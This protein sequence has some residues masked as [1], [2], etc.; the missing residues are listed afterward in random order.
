MEAVCLCSSV[1]LLSNQYDES[2]ARNLIPALNR[3]LEDLRRLLAQ[4]KSL[5][6]DVQFHVTPRNQ[7]TSKALAVDSLDLTP[8]NQVR[9]QFR[10]NIDGFWA[11]S[12]NRR[13]ILS[14]LR[15]PA[16]PSSYYNLFYDYAD[17]LPATDQLLLLLYAYGGSDVPEALLKGVRSPQ[18][19]WNS[20]GEIETVTSDKF[21]LPTELTNLLSDDIECSRATESPYINKHGLED[22]TNVWSLCSELAMFFSR[23]LT[24]KTMD[25]LGNVALKLLCF[26]VPPCYEGNTEWSPTLKAAVWAVMDKATTTFKVPTPLKAE[27]IDALL[28]FSERDHIPM[29]RAAVDRA[30]SF[31]RKPMPYYFH[32][33]VVLSRSNLLRLDGEFAKSEAHIRDFIWRGPQPSTRKDHALLGRL[34][35]SQIENKI[36]CYDNDVSSFIYNWQAEQPLSTLDIEV[37]FR[38]QSTAAR[39]FQSI[40][41]FGAARA[42]I[43]HLMSLD[44]TKPIRQNTRRLLCGRLADIYCNMQE[45][46]MAADILQTELGTTEDAERC[47]RGPRRLLLASAEVDIGLQRLDAAEATLKEL[48]GYEPAE[49]DNLHDQQLHMRLFIDLYI[50]LIITMAPSG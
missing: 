39:F 11:V 26:V 3:H 32:A 22:R 13:L 49:L 44:M 30:K 1:R 38:L 42:S 10:E 41:D 43:E 45:W 29:R 5:S 4:S 18:R 35:I 27:V 21:G 14:Q 20:D 24:P 8:V 50:Y 47:R 23:V 28:Y 37:T 31:L 9:E 33:S 7:R 17:V 6:R 2:Q 25:E 36:K 40:G 34:H 48:E 16:L 15:D 46:A 19:R 12:D